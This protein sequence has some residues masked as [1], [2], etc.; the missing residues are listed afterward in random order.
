MIYGGVNRNDLLI[1]LAHYLL[2]FVFNGHAD[3]ALSSSSVVALSASLVTSRSLCF[4]EM[5]M[6]YL[7]HLPE[8][9]DTVH[10]GLLVMGRVQHEACLL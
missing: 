10:R 2:S 9:V 4:S 6:V 7:C 5:I 1:N 8:R 3:N